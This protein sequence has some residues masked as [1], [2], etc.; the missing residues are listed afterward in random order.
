MKSGDIKKIISI[1]IFCCC[2]VIF[3][4]FPLKAGE[5]GQ[6]ST[7]L[8][9]KSQ[10]PVADM[11]SLPFQNNTN[12][13]YGPDNDVQ[14]VLNIQPVIPFN[15]S[16]K[17]NLITRTIIPVI[18]QPI[19]EHKSG[20][21][22]INFSS[23]FT[24][25]NPTIVGKGAFLYGFGPIIQLPTATNKILGS[26]KWAAG[27]TAVGVYMEGPWVMGLL[28]NQ[29]WSFA[30]ESDRSPVSHMNLQPFINYNLPRGWFITSV[31]LITADWRVK[32]SNVWTV[33]VGGGI[34]KVLNIGKQ[35]FNIAVSGYYNIEK[36]EYGPDW[37]LRVSLS[38]LFP[39]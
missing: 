3:L 31:P 12:F 14:N 37:S 16:K 2:C 15:L 33:P 26:G 11:I 22:D 10:N 30:G 28:V 18:D 20:I 4:S 29:L 7:E 39:K 35:P 24:P 38:L 32:S 34:G 21:G 17:I 23:F 8:A 9:K 1:V 5:N 25:A 6:D 36:P 19:P 27:P 13:R